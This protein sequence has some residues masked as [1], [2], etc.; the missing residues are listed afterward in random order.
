MAQH[1]TRHASRQANLEALAAIRVLREDGMDAPPSVLSPQ[2]RMPNATRAE[3]PVGHG[4]AEAAGPTR[5]APPPALDVPRDVPRDPPLIGSDSAG[6][7][8]SA[9]GPP[10]AAA[11]GWSAPSIG[12]QH[13]IAAGFDY[14][15]VTKDLT[16]RRFDLQKKAWLAE[17]ADVVDVSIRR[18]H[19]YRAVA[20]IGLLEAYR[21]WRVLNADS[22]IGTAEDLWA[23]LRTQLVTPAGEFYGTVH[24]LDARQ[25]P[26]ESV[27]DWRRRLE[28]LSVGEGIDRYVLAVMFIHGLTVV[29]GL[30]DHGVVE[31]TSFQHA[32]GVQRR[33]TI[34]DVLPRLLVYDARRVTA[35]RESR[36]VPGLPDIG[37]PNERRWLP[38]AEPPAVPRAQ[39]RS[40]QGARTFAPAPPVAV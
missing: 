23:W 31:L 19:L 38:A 25:A 29:G 12:E 39:G 22:V 13:R 7:V 11:G 32:D 10:A 33:P 6:D 18:N 17:M 26:T 40:F 37:P 14:A 1:Q 20:A 2:P 5:E 28:A 8:P 4:D 30:R 36:R 9:G 3:G 15:F 21:G 24:L 35:L 16:A 34:D 27:S